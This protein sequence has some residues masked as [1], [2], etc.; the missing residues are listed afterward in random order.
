M[1]FK[2]LKLGNDIADE[3]INYNIQDDK[4]LFSELKKIFQKKIF[5]KIDNPQKKI[6]F[7]LGMQDQGLH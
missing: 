4:N 3:Q 1:S 6:I 5:D 2:F 7:I